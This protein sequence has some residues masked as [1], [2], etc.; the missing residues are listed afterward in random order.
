MASGLNI[1]VFPDPDALSRAVSE[2]LAAQIAARSAGGANVALVLS[3]G[4]TPSTLYRCLAE[5]YR[6]RIPWARMNIFWSDER[7]V[8][9]DDPHSNYRMA[10]ETLLDGVP[11]PGANVHWMP[12]HF[13]DPEDA[14]RAYEDEL[15]QHFGLPVPRFD[16]ILLGMGADGHT[17][18]LF[19]AHQ[20]SRNE[21][22]GWWPR[23]RRWRR[24]C[25]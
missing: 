12:T 13:V 22:A 10:R 8:P 4:N 7:Y 24:M 19:P 5:D 11:V 21:S 1:R 3:G 17:V 14:A 6:D 16:V 20:L 9:H 18:S 25:V 2:H 15:R 23:V